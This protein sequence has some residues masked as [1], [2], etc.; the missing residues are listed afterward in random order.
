[1]FYD[2]QHLAVINNGDVFTKDGVKSI[3]NIGQSYDKQDP[4]KIGRYGIGFKLVHRLV[5]KSSGLDELLNVD[6]Q[7]YKFNFIFL[8]RKITI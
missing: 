1:M 3:L 4:D 6:K 5:G 8:V 7:G 2:E